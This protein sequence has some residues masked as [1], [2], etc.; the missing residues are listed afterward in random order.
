MRPLITLAVFLSVVGCSDD[1]ANHGD[2]APGRDAATRIIHDAGPRLADRGVIPPPI[3]PD[4]EI[5]DEADAYLTARY[6]QL[7]GE[8]ERTLQGG[9]TLSVS[10]RYLDAYDHPVSGKIEAALMH[11]GQPAGLRGISGTHLSEP[12][13]VFALDDGRATFTLEAGQTPVEVT[14]LIQAAHAEPVHVLVQITPPPEGR[15]DLRVFYAEGRYPEGAM[16]EV[17]AFLADGTCAAMGRLDSP[18]RIISPFDGDEII[19]LTA[20]HQA[21]RVAFAHALAN[22]RVIAKGCVEG[23][24]VEGGAVTPVEVQLWDQA[25]EFKGLYDVRH[26]LDFTD[27]MDADQDLSGVA[28]VLDVFGALGGTYGQG[29][30]PRGDGIIRLVC[31]RTGVDPSDCEILRLFGAQIVD[32]MV[33][34]LLSEQA[35]E[36]IDVLGDVHAIVADF[37]V[38]GQMSFAETVADEN[39]M[40]K[41][42]ESRWHGLEFFWTQGCPDDERVNC[43]RRFDLLE[44]GFGQRSVVAAFD[45]RLDEDEGLTLLPHTLELHVGRMVSSLIEAWLLPAILGVEGPMSY[46]QFLADSINCPQIN[47][48]LPPFDPAS[49]LCER[50]I[51]A[52]LAETLRERIAA[53][54]GQPKLLTFEGH[55]TP[56]DFD[57]D[58]RVDHLID[59]VWDISF[60]ADEATIPEAGTFRGCRAGECQL[61]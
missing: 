22:G 48:A 29:P 49:G 37:R 20:P 41:N 46:E 21:Q 58:L 60:G 59:G 40:L 25:L 16:T 19:P 38:Y 36:V 6:L 31:E 15:V 43:T 12:S 51:V 11:D 10:V 33:D 9:Q 2:E 53:I 47:E 50:A 52:P 56:T 44:M 42:N 35:I 17:Q 27:L 3:E 30:F 13:E 32:E 1:S 61:E 54:G 24:I 14:V 4:A 8:A 45:A 39:G 57:P 34:G 28:D 5:I 18:P 26:R 55:V 7:V 23:V